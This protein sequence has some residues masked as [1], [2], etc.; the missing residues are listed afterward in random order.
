M[1]LINYIGLRV[2]IILTNEYYFLGKVI[3]AEDNSLDLIDM[4]GKRV[5]LVK[6]SIFSIQ[7]I[8][9]GN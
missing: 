1:N 7:E 6:S 8:S 5:S 9:N 2:K 4:K 3:S